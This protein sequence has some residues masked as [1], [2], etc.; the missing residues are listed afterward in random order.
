VKDVVSVQRVVWA[1]ND[2][3]LHLSNHP[4]YIQNSA[5]GLSVCL[6]LKFS[7]AGNVLT[8]SCI[9]NSSKHDARSREQNSV[10]AYR[11]S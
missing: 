2:V 8:V 5:K 3:T 10:L 7:A 4:V 6:P 1:I 11:M 9:A